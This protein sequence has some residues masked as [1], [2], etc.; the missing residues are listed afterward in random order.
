M[1]HHA[2]LPLLIG[3]TAILAQVSASDTASATVTLF[4]SLGKLSL[5]AVLL[6]VLWMLWKQYQREQERREQQEKDFRVLMETSLKE[7]TTSNNR[8]CAVMDRVERV[9][10]E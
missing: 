7:N 9:L 5:S 6:V 3:G 8:V 4:E 2:P 10:K 1:I